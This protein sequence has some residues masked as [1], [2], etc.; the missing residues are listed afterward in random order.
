MFLGKEALEPIES[1]KQPF[2]LVFLGVTAGKE[3]GEVQGDCSIAL[4][5][6][7]SSEILYGWF[8]PGS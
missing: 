3:R 5:Y 2:H 7:S 6:F 8:Y 4:T 1:Q